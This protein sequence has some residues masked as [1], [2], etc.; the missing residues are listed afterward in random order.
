MVYTD[1]VHSAHCTQHVPHGSTEYEKRIFFP[2]LSFE[3]YWRLFCC[4][5]CTKL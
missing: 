4:M 2:Y 3:N 1:F 5:V